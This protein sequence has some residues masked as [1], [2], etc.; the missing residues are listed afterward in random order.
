[1]MQSVKEKAHFRLSRVLI[2]Q[3]KIPAMSSWM[4]VKTREEFWENGFA[5]FADSGRKLQKAVFPVA[6]GHSCL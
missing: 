6:C 2:Q 5:M 4:L 1:M 3:V